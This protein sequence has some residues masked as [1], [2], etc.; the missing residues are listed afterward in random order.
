MTGEADAVFPPKSILYLLDFGVGYG[1]ICGCRGIH[2]QSAHYWLKIPAVTVHLTGQLD[3]VLDHRGGQDARLMSDLA[4]GWGE[5]VPLDI[6]LA[7]F[8]D[9]LLSLRF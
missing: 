3:V 2:T 9:L 1:R 8:Q 6:I 7:V 4:H 5:A